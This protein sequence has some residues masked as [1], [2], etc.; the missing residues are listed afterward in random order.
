[1]AA[2]L[3]LRGILEDLA[4]DLSAHLP[5]TRLGLALLS[6]DRRQFEVPAV[7][8]RDREICEP[9]KE[10][11]PEGSIGGWSCESGLPFRGSVS[12]DS[13]EFAA[14]HA[15]MKREGM[16]ANCVIPLRRDG[17]WSGALFALSPQERAFDADALGSLIAAR[18]AVEALLS[19]QARWTSRENSEANFSLDELQ[20]RHIREVLLLSGGVIEGAAGAARRLELAPSTL[21]NRMR[22]L[23][24]PRR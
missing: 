7:F 20:R 22:R 21:R 23:G 5:F 18:P 16:A 2:R 17:D 15:Y 8:D 3:D 12:D 6:E 19:A 11:S 14:T 9:G 13:A 10:F 24:I 4:R 1:M